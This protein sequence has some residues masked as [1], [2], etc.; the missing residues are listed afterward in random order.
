MVPAFVSV[1]LGCAVKHISIN[2]KN[3][4]KN[5][6]LGKF[7]ENPAQLTAFER[8]LIENELNGIYGHAI[9]SNLVVDVGAGASAGVAQKPDNL[10]AFH[11]LAG[12]DQDL[13]QMS[14]FGLFPISVVDGDQF[15]DE[16]FPGGISDF[17]VG[18]GDDFGA[19]AVGDVQAG[20]EIPFA[21]EGRLAI[22][23]FG[24]D[25][26]VHRSDGGGGGQEAFFLF[27]FLD[28]VIEIQFLLLGG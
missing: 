13:L 8:N 15:A 17:T 3:K 6:Q 21:G 10:A 1:G 2:R 19:G 18:R 26:A 4:N 7:I 24:G 22:S 28:Q 14:V 12:F 16:Y 20:M 27:Q 25:P 11:P 5:F 23:E 9:D